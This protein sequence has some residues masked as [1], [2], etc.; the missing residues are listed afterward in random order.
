MGALGR[1]SRVAIRPVEV[2][3]NAAATPSG[4]RCPGDIWL[5][6]TPGRGGKG[7]E[8]LHCGMLDGRNRAA[9]ALLA[10][11]LSRKGLPRRGVAHSIPEWTACGADCPGARGTADTWVLVQRSAETSNHDRRGADSTAFPHHREEMPLSS[12]LLGGGVLCAARII[13]DGLSARAL[14]LLPVGLGNIDVEADRDRNV[15]APS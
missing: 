3:C 12:S 4:P 15:G 9:A 8:T 7:I 14:A 5:G 13:R 1:S 11:V 6:H 10:P 2:R